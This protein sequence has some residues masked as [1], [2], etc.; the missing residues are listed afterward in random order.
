LPLQ[1]LARYV[2]TKGND[3]STVFDALADEIQQRHNVGDVHGLLHGALHRGIVLP[4]FDGLDEVPVEGVPGERASRLET[5][6]AVRA[7]ALLYSKPKT[8][9]QTQ[10]TSADDQA[11]TVPIVVTCRENAFTDDLRDCLG[12]SVETLAP[13]D[14][15]Q[16][17]QFVPAWY[18]ELA[19]KTTLT[20]KT[21]QRYSKGLVELIESSRQLT[22]MAKTPLLLTMI[23]LVIY[24]KGNLLRDNDSLKGKLPR[25]NDSLEGK[26]PR[27]RSKLFGNILDLLL[28]RWDTVQERGGQTL[29]EYIG[30][31]NW[32]SE[33]FLPMLD[34]LSYEAHRTAASEDRC[35]RLEE[36][37]VHKKL[38]E[39][40]KQA[41]LSQVTAFEKTGR[42]LEYIQQRSG[43]LM[44]D[45]DE[46]YVFAHLTLQEHCAGR[47]IVLGSE[48][49][50]R[51]VLEHRT[52]DRWREPIM[53]GLGLAPP[54]DLD[55]VLEALLK[56]KEA[57]H[58]K[59]VERWY[60]D[61]IL[62]AEIGADREWAYL[63]TLPRIKVEEHQEQLS[64]GLAELLNDPQPPLPYTDRVRAGFL[65]GDL[66]H[67]P[68]L[69]DPATG[70][71]PDRRYWCPVEVGTFW[72]GDDRPQRDD[73]EKEAE[74]SAEEREQRR[75]ARLQQLHL[76]YA[77]QI[78][79]FPVTNGEYARF[80]EAKGYEQQEW[81]TENGWDWKGSR[82]EPS[83][84][85]DSRYNN[86]AQ[87]VVGVTWWEAAAYCRWLTAQGHTQGWLPSTQEIRLPTSLEWERAVRHTDQRPYPWGWEEPT[88]ERANYNETGIGRPSPVGCFPAGGAVCGAQ[89]LAG[90]VLEWL[91]TSDERHYQVVPERNFALDTFMLCSHSK[92]NDERLASI[93]D[94]WNRNNSYNC[95]FVL[96]FRIIR[97]RRSVGDKQLR[98][99]Q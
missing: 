4:L 70:T 14:I 47:Y 38:I 55:D 58:C 97:I 30:M 74:L 67:D 91:A 24:Y 13:F 60:R 44:P 1:K 73:R 39:F 86:L 92:F 81:W 31:P 59:P 2:A 65:L 20:T 80:I 88:P 62:A 21:A 98:G 35:G 41:R 42:C 77:F 52:D 78:A 25:D 76:D 43:L 11:E 89:D 36:G 27:D 23:S 40:F 17:R 71:S 9:R 46:S 96:G 49:P 72:Y 45:G 37:V 79:R 93:C 6:Q 51:L 10:N 29:A 68:R 50:A 22:E 7:F 34:R 85:D 84:W 90:N 16:V 99:E 83:Y 94:L 82:T 63:Q 69:L 75:L 53:L 33:R 5:V 8:Q 87:P 15:D 19:E 32:D 12:W 48:D 28:G 61:L 66:G 56:R 3:A 18:A 95:A 64:Q 54:A 26:L 57:R